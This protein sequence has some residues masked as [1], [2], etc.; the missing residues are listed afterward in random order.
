MSK[1]QL[2]TL[3]G[4]NIRK[5]RLAH[6]MTIDQLSK[7][8]GQSPGFVGLIE[9]GKRGAT[10]DTLLKLAKIFDVSIDSFFGHQQNIQ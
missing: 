7:S 9:S 6:H 3:I 2:R 8:L 10:S 4:E 5:E 1:E